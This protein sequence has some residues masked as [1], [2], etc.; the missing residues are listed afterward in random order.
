MLLRF[1]A[2]GKFFELLLAF[3]LDLAEKA[4]RKRC[5]ICKA[6]LHQAHYK[7]KPRGGPADLDEDHSCRFSF[8]CYL[9]RKR[10]TPPS[11]RFLGRRIYFGMIMVLVS[12]MLGG[13]SPRRLERLRELC[14]A[15]KKTLERWRTWWAETFNQSK[16]WKI[17]SASF[18]LARASNI[19]LPRLFFRTMKASSFSETLWQV[20][21]FLLP[22]TSGAGPG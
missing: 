14:G 4:R 17:H 15:D 3:D 10:L 9:C 7:R 20:L 18:A 19:S 12:A 13:A 21:Q 11:L 16:F 2:D 6:N 8:C 1:F 22:L 5:L